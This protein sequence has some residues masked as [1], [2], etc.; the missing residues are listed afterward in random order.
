MQPSGSEAPMGE[1]SS[2]KYG[3]SSAE[4]GDMRSARTAFE[5]SLRAGVST[6]MWRKLAVGKRRPASPTLSKSLSKSGQSLP[7][8]W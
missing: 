4:W 8:Y 6:L 7:Y 5:G 1:V 2:V 3:R